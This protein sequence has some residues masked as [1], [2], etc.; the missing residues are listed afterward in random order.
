MRGVFVCVMITTTMEKHR[1]VARST[2]FCQSRG[3]TVG[4][5]GF[6][7]FCFCFF[8]FLSIFLVATFQK[9]VGTKIA[10]YHGTTT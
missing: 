5:V 8:S 7:F 3:T 9:L 2:T 4:V 1:P 6:F 10:Y